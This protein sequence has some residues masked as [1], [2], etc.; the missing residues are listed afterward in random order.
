[1][2]DEGEDLTP[3]KEEE[4]SVLKTC[5]HFIKFLRVLRDR[6]DEGLTPDALHQ[7]R[8]VE[9]EMKQYLKGKV[10]L[11]TRE[12]QTDYSE[13]I[14]AVDTKPVPTKTEMNT[15]E[16]SSDSSLQ[17]EASTLESEESSSD[18]GRERRKRKRRGTRQTSKGIDS[19]VLTALRNIDHRAI[20]KQEVFSESSGQ[21]FEQYLSRFEEYCLDTFRG[22]KYL[23][24][25]ELERHLSGKIL[26]GFHSLRDYNDSYEEMREKLVSWYKD[27]RHLRR[28]AAKKFER[29]KMKPKESLF[30]FGTRL[31]SLFKAAFP[32]HRVNESKTLINTYLENIPKVTKGEINSQ[33][34]TYKLKHKKV[35]WSFILKCARLK[36][37]ERDSRKQSS[38]EE[39]PEE[40]VINLSK[41]A[42]KYED[43]RPRNH[44]SSNKGYINHRHNYQ[45]ETP[46][47]GRRFTDPPE[48]EWCNICKRFG[49]S[50]RNCRRRLRACFN[51]GASD[52]FIKDCNRG[53]HNSFTRAPYQQQKGHLNQQ[54]TSWNR[55][56]SQYLSRNRRN[57]YSRERQSN[58]HPMVRRSSSCQGGRTT[59]SSNSYQR[60][61]SSN[62]YQR[63]IANSYKRPMQ[64]EKSNT[65]HTLPSRHEVN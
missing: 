5:E 32:T 9:D 60:E 27:S 61:N 35:T 62:S 39:K 34:M 1:M 36:D 6:G 24:I 14:L 4:V 25:P 19:Q 26:E 16:T 49:H 57:S 8:L 17:S 53:M 51:C 54:S 56:S 47:P 55:P 33:V 18:T 46:A 13:A 42:E 38:E 30:L 28:S 37:T 40:I 52:H 23:W 10:K 48:S 63:E 7:I 20:P 50:F 64:H 41:A 65:S 12:V 58:N 44:Y 22:R 2:T 45:P 29:A 43:R 3:E 59:N 31:E 11:Q 15:I 21:D